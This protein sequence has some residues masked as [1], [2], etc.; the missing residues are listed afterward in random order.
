M[1]W[2]AVK[3]RKLDLYQGNYKR[4][5]VEITNVIDILDS[6]KYDKRMNGEIYNVASDN[7]TKTEL[8]EKIKQFVPNLEVNYS[9]EEDIDKRS[10]FLDTTKIERLGY[11]CKK[12]LDNSLQDLIKFYEIVDNNQENL[13][14]LRFNKIQKNKIKIPNLPAY[15]DPSSTAMRL[16]GF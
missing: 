7:F 13:D 11:F 4:T 16:L 10:Y 2:Q 3:T 6:W 12:N 9:D 15:D 5:Y 1:V 14:R 8:V